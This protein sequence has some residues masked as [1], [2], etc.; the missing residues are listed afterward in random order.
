M[1]DLHNEL[2]L[3]V[4][5]LSQWLFYYYNQYRFEGTIFKEENAVYLLLRNVETKRPRNKLDH[6]KFGP[7]LVK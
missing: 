7:F 2:A 4:E 1:K 6:K 3:D 5:F